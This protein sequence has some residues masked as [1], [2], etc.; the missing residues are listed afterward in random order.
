MASA[1]VIVNRW[2]GSTGS[3]TKTDISSTN[4]RANAVDSHSTGGT[5]NPIKIPGSGTNY[6]YW[7]STRLDVSTNSSGNTIDNIKW[8]TDGGAFTETGV[9][10]NVASASAYEQATGTTAETGDALS[11]HGSLSN[12]VTGAFTYTSGSPLS[13]SGSTTG[14]GDFGDFVVYQV[15]VSANA[16][17][18]TTSQETFTWQY[19]ETGS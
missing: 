9:D 13:V 19:D 7:V 17:P 16:S 12:S 5:S 14:T 10:A 3:P 2:T 4:T 11:G 8:Y 18:Q 1:T 6:S 15:T